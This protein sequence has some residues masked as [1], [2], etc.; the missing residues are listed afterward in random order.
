MSL[1]FLLAGSG[2]WLAFRHRGPGQY[3]GERAKRLLIPFV[4]GL[5]VIVPPQTWWGY[6]WHGKG[7]V[8][9]WDYYPKFWTT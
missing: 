7:D 4:F 9:Y 3:V 6:L 1:L 5:V 8:S 2:T